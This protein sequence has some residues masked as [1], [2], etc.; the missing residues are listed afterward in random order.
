MARRNSCMSAPKPKGRGLGNGPHGRRSGI[1]VISFSPLD[2]IFG[3]TC[4]AAELRNPS[5]F[6]L[7]HDTDWLLSVEEFGHSD[8]T[9]H[10]SIAMFEFDRSSGSL[11][12]LGSV[13]AGGAHPCHLELDPPGR[14]LAVMNYTSGGTQSIS[15]EPCR[16]MIPIGAL[17]NP[18]GTGPH[19]ERQSKAHPH[20]PVFDP[21]GRY[22]TS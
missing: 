11:H 8:R 14:R 20:A 4:T 16:P 9:R 21:K 10:G 22:F 2:G 1:H 15:T 3:A 13:K 19:Q 17:V 18:P 12:L 7:H 6:I 5:H